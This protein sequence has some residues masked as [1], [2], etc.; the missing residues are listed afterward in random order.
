MNNLHSADVLQEAQNI[1][2]GDT[3]SVVLKQC[4]FMTP[5]PSPDPSTLLAMYHTAYLPKTDFWAMSEFFGKKL[6]L[7]HLW[8]PGTKRCHISSLHPDFVHESEM[9]LANLFKD[10]MKTQI[11]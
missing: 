10:E 3:C 8:F 4:P 5:I 1:S 7:V 2:Q 6:A 9:E 11:L